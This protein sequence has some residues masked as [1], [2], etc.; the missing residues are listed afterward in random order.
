MTIYLPP[1]VKRSLL[2][3]FIDENITKR[4][5]VKKEMLA[6]KAAGNRSEQNKSNEQNSL[7]DPEQRFVWCTPHRLLFCLTS[8]LTLSYINVS[9][10]H[11]L[12]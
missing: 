7:K 2:S 12:R 3:E 11:Q 10:C 1:S 6:A 4:G 5:K 8:L 9:F